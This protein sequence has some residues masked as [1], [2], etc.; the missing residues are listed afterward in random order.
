MGLYMKN[1]FFTSVGVPLILRMLKR[2][3]ISEDPWNGNYPVSIS[4]MT[5]PI[6]HMSTLTL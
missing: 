4:K 2:Y 6:D 3:S 5:T 1:T